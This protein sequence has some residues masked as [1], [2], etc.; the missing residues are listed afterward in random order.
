[1]GNDCVNLGAAAH[2]ERLL[3]SLLHRIDKDYE[4]RSSLDGFCKHK[5]K[6]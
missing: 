6:R 5:G 2:D 4:K 1:M 3:V